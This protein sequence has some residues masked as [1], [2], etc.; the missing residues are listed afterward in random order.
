MSSIALCAAKL[1]MI[2]TAGTLLA[3]CTY[4]ETRVVREF[5]GVL[6]HADTKRPIEGAPIVLSE[7]RH[8]YVPFPFV[9][10]RFQPIAHTLTDANGRFHFSVCMTQSDYDLDWDQGS[11]GNGDWLVVEPAKVQVRLYTKPPY[12]ELMSERIAWE[13]EREDSSFTQSCL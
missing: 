10:D 4:F 12:D 2:L 7:F 3:S 5:S 1:S 11:A 13:I 9:L 8:P 6:L